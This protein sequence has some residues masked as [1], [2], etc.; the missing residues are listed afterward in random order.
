MVLFLTGEGP[1]TPAGVDGEIVAATNL[2]RPLARVGIRVDGQDVPAEDV[3][4]AGSA[5]GLVSG[6]MQINFRLPRSL[7]PNPI[8]AIE[9]AVGESRSPSGTTIAVQ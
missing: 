6:V 1:T 5:P 8:A 7:T 3:A 2:K 4:Y 9:V